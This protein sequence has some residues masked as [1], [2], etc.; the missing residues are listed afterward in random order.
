[1]KALAYVLKSINFKKTYTGVTTD[2]DKR[3]LEHNRGC[4]NF[5]RKYKPWKVFYTEEY[6]SMAEAKKREKYL[7]S[8]AGRKFLKTLFNK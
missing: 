8:H 7:K 3:L 4:N 5:T 1:M 2:I 6:K